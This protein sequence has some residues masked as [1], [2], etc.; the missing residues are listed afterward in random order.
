MATPLG[1]AFSTDEKDVPQ[2]DNKSIGD[3]AEILVI[4][5][6]QDKFEEM[7]SQDGSSHHSS[8]RQRKVSFGNQVS[9]ETKATHSSTK[10]LPELVDTKIE[11]TVHDKCAC[12]DRSAYDGVLVTAVASSK[13]EL[14]YSEL[15]AQ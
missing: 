4:K 7:I 6:N 1:S 14:P 10:A 8:R 3:N 12:P 11:E 13:N 9:H 15:S 5:F 2:C